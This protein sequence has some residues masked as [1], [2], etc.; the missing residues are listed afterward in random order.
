[1]K[2]IIMAK[3]FSDSKEHVHLSS[4]TSWFRH[5]KCS[6]SCGGGV[7]IRTRSCHGDRDSD[8]H[9]RCSGS[10]VSTQPCNTH[11]CPDTCMS[12]VLVTWYMH[13][14]LFKIFIYCGV[15][16]IRGGPLFRLSLVSLSHEFTSPPT[17]I[18]SLLTTTNKID[19]LINIIWTTK[20]TFMHSSSTVITN[21][22]HLKKS[23]FRY[24]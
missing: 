22:L 20:Q 8:H 5:S 11:P 3:I 12:T 15:N 9:H 10:T 4:W 13:H 24:R 21:Y 6:V 16:T 2:R 19:S 17:Y 1:M 23:P 14:A 7:Q 18:Q